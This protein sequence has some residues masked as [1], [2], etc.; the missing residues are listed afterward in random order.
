M[1]IED[2]MHNNQIISDILEENERLYREIGE[3]KSLVD[4]E[5]LIKIPKG[6]ISKIPTLINRYHLN[7]IIRDE[8][9]KKNVTYLLQ[10]IDLDQF[11]YNRFYIWGSVESMTLKLAQV[12]YAAFIETLIVEVA[13]EIR[14]KCEGC[15]ERGRGC[16]NMISKA[17]AGRMKKALERLVEIGAVT[18]DEET[19]QRIVT[20]Y[21]S[22]NKIHVFLTYSIGNEYTNG[23]YSAN[24]CNNSIELLSIVADD[25]Y[26]HAVPLYDDLSCREQP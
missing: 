26:N 21:N 19:L 5:A 20:L 25:L 9:V 17:D 2:I 10:R 6:Y 7:E 8:S 12:V 16:N 14:K 24:G 23:E 15:P 11:I 13:T 18:L 1:S 4:R 22:R 3:E